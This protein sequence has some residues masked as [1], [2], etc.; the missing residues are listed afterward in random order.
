MGIDEAIAG[1]FLFCASVCKHHLH[2]MRAH[3]GESIHHE[4][5][6]CDTTLQ[7]VEDLSGVAWEDRFEPDRG[8]SA[9]DK[10]QEGDC[11]DDL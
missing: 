4:P 10:V 5:I 3:Q 8:A 6:A 2:R 1:S 7:V 11:L 9:N